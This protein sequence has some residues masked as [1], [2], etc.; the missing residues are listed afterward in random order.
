MKP[1]AKSQIDEVSRPDDCQRIWPSIQ[2]YLRDTMYIY[3]SAEILGVR[4]ATCCRFLLIGDGDEMESHDVA[5]DEN[6]YKTVYSI[7]F[8]VI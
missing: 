6:N 8:Q 4:T 3:I 1:T 5:S 2:T 7:K